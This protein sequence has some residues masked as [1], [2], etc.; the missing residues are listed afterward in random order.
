MPRSY[1]EVITVVMCH[2][3]HSKFKVAQYAQEAME[4][5][6]ELPED[7]KKSQ[8]GVISVFEI[9]EVKKELSENNILESLNDGMIPG[10]SQNIKPDNKHPKQE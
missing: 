9:D 3:C 6:E 2:K 10:A 4:Y 1:S 5:F 8:G 7:T